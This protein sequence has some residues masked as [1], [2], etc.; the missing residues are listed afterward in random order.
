MPLTTHRSYPKCLYYWNA[1]CCHSHDPATSAATTAATTHCFCSDWLCNKKLLGFL[2]T[3]CICNVIERNYFYFLLP[4]RYHIP[5]PLLSSSLRFHFLDYLKKSWSGYCS[6]R[7]YSQRYLHERHINFSLSLLAFRIVN[8]TCVSECK[9][10][11]K[12]V[13]LTS[14]LL[15]LMYTDTKITLT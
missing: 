14:R 8:L 6:I 2:K 11:G 13:F 10:K 15:I 12:H 9:N 4:V 1:C 7:I 5:Q 3:Q